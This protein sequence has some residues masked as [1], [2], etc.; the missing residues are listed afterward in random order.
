MES[1]SWQIEHKVNL[2]SKLKLESMTSIETTRLI[3]TLA[4]H[5][6]PAQ[7][8]EPLDGWLMR[9]HS[10]PSRRV[11]SVWPNAWGGEIPLALKLERV[12]AYYARLG[13]PAI[14]QV[15]PANLPAS[16]DDVLAARGYT[17]DAPTAVQT[18]NIDTAIQRISEP[19]AE[20]FISETLTD[21][22][23]RG[24]VLAEGPLSAQKLAQ[25]RKALARVQP[26]SAYVLAQVDGEP[27]AVGRGVLE[28][29][30]LGIF[31]MATRPAYR[32]MGLATSLLGALAQWG[33]DQGAGELYLQVM[34]N[35]PGARAL[36]GRLGFATLYH[37]HYRQQ[38]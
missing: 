9:H 28:A 8:N 21:R 33:R 36:Y 38:T 27:A 17:V 1:L 20:L 30:W 19:A 29:G 25:R 4:L 12:E 13:Q 10:V 16:L 11:N 22:W 5:A 35:N 31:G 37:Y 24:C 14:Y 32:R 18:V 7:T 2:N 26:R 34:E 6:W 15:S 3:E 23:L